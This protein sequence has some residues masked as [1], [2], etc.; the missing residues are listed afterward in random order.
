MELLVSLV[1]LD[2]LVPLALLAQS[3][4]LADQVEMVSLEGPDLKEKLEH[5]VSPEVLA[6]MDN[7]VP[8]A[9]NLDQLDLKDLLDLQASMALPVK[10]VSPVDQELQAKMDFQVDLVSQVPTFIL[11]PF[12]FC[13][14]L[15]K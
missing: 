7:L 8:Q 9:D 14:N 10:T 2:R 5:L 11:L 6:E 3:V 13:N 15:F 4:L 12:L 1:A